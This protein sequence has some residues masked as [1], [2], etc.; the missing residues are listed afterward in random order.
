MTI[1]ERGNC[2]S[3]YIK[4]DSLHWNLSYRSYVSGTTETYDKADQDLVRVTKTS[5]GG[6]VSEKSD[7]GVLIFYTITE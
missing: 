5:N 7:K 6:S 3:F 4:K 2:E 1:R